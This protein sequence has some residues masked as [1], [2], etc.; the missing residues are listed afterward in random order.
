MKE[1]INKI[2]KRF[3]MGCF[4]FFIAV[5]VLVKCSTSNDSTASKSST[6]TTTTTTAETT[7]KADVSQPK[8]K[9][10]WQPKEIAEFNQPYRSTD[11]KN[12]DGSYLIL[13]V[14]SIKKRDGAIVITSY[15][16]SNEA[17]KYS[18]DNFMAVDIFDEEGKTLSATLDNIIVNPIPEDGLEIIITGIDTT[19]AKWVEIMPYKTINNN[20]ITFELK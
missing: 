1:K 6:E 9:K 4:I 5:M 11:Y 3:V 16:P 20:F 17:I 8:E 19:K 13:N 7:K 15:A 18:L 10:A 2:L 14:D 12:P